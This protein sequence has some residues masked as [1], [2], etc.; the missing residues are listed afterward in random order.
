M[1]DDSAEIQIRRIYNKFDSLKML[2]NLKTL[3]FYNSL[4]ILCL[5]RFIVM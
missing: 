4:H 2:T 1:R 5:T 3:K